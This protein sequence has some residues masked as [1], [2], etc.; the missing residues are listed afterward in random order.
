MDTTK[1]PSYSISPT[2]LAA[3]LRGPVAPLVVD[4]RKNEAFDASAYLLPGALRRDPLQ[5]AQWAATL[6]VV[7]SV[8]VYCIHGHEVSQ[9]TVTALR[10]RGINAS[11]L[12]GGI[13]A[14]REQTLPLVAKPVGNGTRWVTRERPRIDRIACPWLVRRF[15][16]AGAQFLYV[17]TDQVAAVAQREVAMAY[18]VGPH[19][20]S[21]LFTHEGERCSFDAFIKHYGLAQDAALLRLALIVRGADTDRLDL[22]PQCA[23][24]VAVSLGMA[25]THSEDA[26]MLETLMPVY[27]AL[28]AWCRDAVAGQDEKHTWKSA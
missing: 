18:D 24:L 22:A 27:D 28:Y 11:F 25:R 9:G 21:T 2:A 13:E 3:Q 8:L 1:P 19:V 10:Q 17:P 7:A 26:A 6:P 5:V 16:D 23:G 20:A 12:Q 15:V 4:V 14:W